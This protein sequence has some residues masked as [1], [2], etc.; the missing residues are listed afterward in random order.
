[1]VT[2]GIQWVEFGKQPVII[3]ERI[4]PT[5]KPK[6]KQALRDH[7]IP[8]VLREGIAQQDAGAHVLDVNVGLP[9]I[10]EPALMLP[11]GGRTPSRVFPAPA[12]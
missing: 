4:N 11:G 10:D 6:F 1:M 12:D 2:S 3:G 8:Y 7:D 9:E 5:G